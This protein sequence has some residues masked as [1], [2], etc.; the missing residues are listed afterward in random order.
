MSNV[1]VFDPAAFKVVFDEFATVPDAKLNYYFNLAA[2]TILDNSENACIPLAERTILFDLLVAHQAELKK[3]IEEGNSGL[4][5][6]I[7]SA[8]EGSVSISTDYQIQGNTAQWYN[9]TPYGAQYWAMTAKYRTFTY[10]VTNEAMPV[11][12]ARFM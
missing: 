6:R 9:Q 3:R 5:G 7:S 2:T 11:D 1:V 12:R 4:V 10:V 8:S